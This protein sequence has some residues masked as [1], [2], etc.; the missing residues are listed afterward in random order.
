MARKRY[1]ALA[2]A[3][4]LLAL[5]ALAP[6]GDKGHGSMPGMHGG[7]S[8]EGHG[9]M[10]MGD[11]I[12]DGMIGPWHGEARLVDMKAQMEKA[13][14]S[15]M[16]MMEGMMKSHHI[17]IGLTDPATKEAVTEGSGT[18]TVTG[19]GVKAEKTAFM[20]MEGHF[21]ADVNLPKPGTYT[22]NVEIEAGGRKGAAI[23]ERTVN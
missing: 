23:F 17:S 4:S 6:A 18:I 19:P 1:A 3:L 14:D 11:K 10:K 12:F 7:S 15:G 2:L 13:K 16:K 21:G 8:M 22:F 9:M 5:P 20:V